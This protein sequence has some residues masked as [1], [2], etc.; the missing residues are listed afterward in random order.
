LHVAV[1]LAISVTVHVTIVVP[2]GKVEGALLLTAKLQLSLAVGVP[3]TTV[4]V[5]PCLLAVTVRFAAQ[6]IIGLSAYY[7]DLV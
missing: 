2:N 4:A 7:A 6:L 5:Q 3:R 1:L